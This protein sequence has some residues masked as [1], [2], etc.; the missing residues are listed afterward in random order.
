MVSPTSSNRSDGRHDV[1]RVGP[2]PAT[3]LEQ[4]ARLAD[5]EQL[6]QQAFLGAARQQGPFFG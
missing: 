5:L 3:H 1:G 4:P 2:L 6:V